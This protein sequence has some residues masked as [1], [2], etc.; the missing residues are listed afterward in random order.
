MSDKQDK[1]FLD[2]VVNNL[3]SKVMKVYKEPSPEYK[4][5]TNK[6]ISVSKEFDSIIKN[7]YQ[8]YLKK[9]VNDLNYPRPLGSDENRKAAQYVMDQFKELGYKPHYINELKNVIVNPGAS[10]FIG[11][12]YDTV[13]TTPGADDNSS[14]VA[15]MLAV[16]KIMEGE[17]RIGFICFNAEENGLLGSR[18]YVE[19][20]TKQEIKKHSIIHVLEMVGYTNKAPNSQQNPLPVGEMP[21]VGDFL[22]VVGNS[23]AASSIQSILSCS[24]NVKIPVLALQLSKIP[25]V[26]IPSVLKLSDH[27]PFWNNGLAATQWT[28]TAF[29]R[30]PNYHLASDTPETLDYEFM[31]EVTKLLAL[32]AVMDAAFVLKKN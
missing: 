4:D 1:S 11:S 21:N 28:D 16:A 18:Q 29:H 23:L 24:P 12:H 20:L 9:I 30:N 15:V 7:S 19:S 22:G 25:A 5:L 32:S 2:L 26:A 10:V 3:F 6:V 13:P 8:D 27:A 31:S 14:A 17:S